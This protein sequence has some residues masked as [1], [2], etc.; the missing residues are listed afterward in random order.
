MYFYTNL[1]I[2]TFN[3]TNFKDIFMNEFE[4]RIATSYSLYYWN[5]KRKFSVLATVS[6]DIVWQRPNIHWSKHHT[7]YILP[8]LGVICLCFV[9][10]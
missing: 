9:D 3:S 1:N 2:N 10:I 5:E 7:M 6:P 8:K 4:F